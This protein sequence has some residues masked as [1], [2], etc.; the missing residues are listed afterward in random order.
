MHRWRSAR[1]AEAVG[2]GAGRDRRV[3]EGTGVLKNPGY[4]TLVAKENRLATEIQELRGIFVM[5]RQK[6]LPYRNAVGIV[7]LV[8][9]V[10]ENTLRSAGISQ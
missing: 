4:F 8:I 5:S 6:P 3:G 7:T 10:L 2:G 9:K 1:S